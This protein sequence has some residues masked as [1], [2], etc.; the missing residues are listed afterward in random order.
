MGTEG[1]VDYGAPLGTLVAL[2][3]SW[4]LRIPKSVCSEAVVMRT[5]VSRVL[6]R[7]MMGGA[8]R[9]LQEV[10]R[11]LV[12]LGHAAGDEGKVAGEDG[13]DVLRLALGAASALC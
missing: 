1:I 8:A 12:V 4:L 2:E 11:Q 6:R 5:P 13:L 10:T 9:R 3:P 7:A